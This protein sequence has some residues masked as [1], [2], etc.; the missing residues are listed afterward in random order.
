MPIY[1]LKDDITKI[2]CDVIVN[3]ANS[4]LL[5][6]GGVDGDI[7]KAAGPKLLEE[8]K[9]LDGCDTGRV[10]ITRAYNLKAKYIFHTVGPLYKGGNYHESELLEACYHNCMS[11]AYHLNAGCIAFP[12][13]STGVY[14]YPK[15][16]AAEIAYATVINFL[17]TH[18]YISEPDIYFICFEDISYKYYL[19]LHN[20]K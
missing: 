6:G 18:E 16:E 1:I 10:K 9:K 5:G 3:A 15:R 17:K 8:C 14:H 4:T 11:E 7:H 13:I 2:S 19:N 12:C 20:N